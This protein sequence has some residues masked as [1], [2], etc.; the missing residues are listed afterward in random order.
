[1][2]H[3]H[4]TPHVTGVRLLDNSIIY[5]NV[6]VNCTGMWARQFGAQ[7]GVSIPNQAAEHYYVV[8]DKISGIDPNW[9]VIEDPASYTYIRPEGDG[10]MIGLFEGQGAAWNSGAI[11]TNFSFGQISPD[12]ER[13]SPYLGKAMERVPPSMNVGI[14]NF[15]CGPE[16]FSPDGNPIVGESPELKNYFVAAGMNSIGVLSAGGIGRILAQWIADGKPDVDVTQMNINRFQKFHCTEAY[17]TS[18]VGETLG[19]VYKCHYPFK[20]KQTARGGKRSPIHEYLRRSGAYFKD[21]SGWE[22]PDWYSTG[23]GDSSHDVDDFRTY[24]SWGRQSWFPHWKK[25]HERCRDS[26]VLFDMSFMSKFLVQGPDAGRCLNYLCT[27]DIDT[28]T[29][30]ERVTYTQFLNYDGNIEADVT[31]TK[32]NNNKFLVIATDTMHRQVESW[33]NHHINKDINRVFLSDVTGSFAMFSIQGPNSR[34]LIQKITNQNMDNSNFPYRKSKEIEIGYC[35]VQCSRITYVGELGYELYVPTENAAHVY[36]LIQEAGKELGLCHAGLKALSSL[37]LEKGYR[38]YGHDIDN[39]D[40]LFHVGLS[41]TAHIDKKD[42]FMGRNAVLQQRDAAKRQGG[43]HRRLVHVLVLDP[44]PLMYHAEPLYRDNICVGD[45]RSASYGHTLGGAVGL[46]MVE[47]GSTGFSV[48]DKQ[49][50]SNGKWE[51]D[52]AGKR[53]PVAVSVTPFYDAKN[54]RIRGTAT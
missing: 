40:N 3:N 38:D 39:M 9:P 37:R 49:F 30:N 32:L 42:G 53:Y 15:F 22:S 34:L 28:D 54:D 51:V 13:I 47:V 19:D 14:K 35:H 36:E 18:R 8:T 26:V 52:I 50:V 2:N 24:Q 29:N 21:V 48:I 27:S 10:L 31:I 41:Y 45:V 5:A 23:V 12:F 44:D 33:M 7:H 11:P 43:V 17:R 20:I 1:M 25:E 6:V 4:R 46:G 16:S